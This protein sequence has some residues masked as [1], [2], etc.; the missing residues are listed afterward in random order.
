MT[1]NLDTLRLR[2][3]M[4]VF[5]TRVV[6]REYAPIRDGKLADDADVDPETGVVRGVLPAGVEVRGHIYLLDSQVV[7]SPSMTGF[8]KTYFPSTFDAEA[9]AQR[10]S[11]SDRMLTDRA[12]DYYQR[13]REHVEAAWIALDYDIGELE[14]AYST[15]PN[16]DDPRWKK[17]REVHDPIV[18]AVILKDWE[19]NGC[20]QSGLGKEMHRSIELFFNENV[21]SGPRFETKEYGY[22]CDF[23]KNWVLRK[24]LVMY[25]TELS[26]CDFEIRLCGMIDAMFVYKADVDSGKPLARCVLVDWKRAKD[27]Q[28]KSYKRSPPTFAKAP[29]DHLQLCD[30]SKYY[31]QLNGYKYILQKYTTFRVESMHI[32]V[33]HPTEATFRVHD[34]PEL[35]TQFAICVANAR[36]AMCMPAAISPEPSALTPPEQPAPPSKPAVLKRTL[37]S[38][39]TNKKP[40]S[41]PKIAAKKK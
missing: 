7:T 13:G 4:P 3:P 30:G 5:D 19:D 24:G 40:A 2:N 33:F 35:Q 10:I 29:F 41:K 21:L 14:W 28:F 20:L 16:A 27:L 8:L 26:L 32:A 38:S 36:A 15:K 11:S 37:T 6:F 39:A 31:A 17:F 18:K 23:Y 1:E 9:E 25:R 22:F 12:Y 34:V